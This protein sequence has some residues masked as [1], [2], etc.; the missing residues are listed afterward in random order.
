MKKNLVAEMNSEMARILKRED[1][2]GKIILILHRDE[3]LVMG[4]AVEMKNK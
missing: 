1:N 2:W 3:S 4:V